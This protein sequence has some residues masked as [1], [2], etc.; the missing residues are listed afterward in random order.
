MT[1]ALSS[2]ARVATE[3]ASSFL[4]ELCEHFT[5]ESRRHFGQEIAVS[6]GD[7]DGFV[8]FA[9]F[10]SGTLRLDAREEGVL[11][12]EASGSDQAGLARVQQI[13]SENLE[14][15]GQSDRLTVQ[16]APSTG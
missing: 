1:E 14:R 2:T 16:W 7:D 6:F 9:P 11:A 5:H 8:D 4:K 10:V 12:L 3:R 13:V 15:L